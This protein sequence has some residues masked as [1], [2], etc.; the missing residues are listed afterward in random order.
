MIMK[1]IR[2][3]MGAGSRG[4]SL[5]RPAAQMPETRGDIGAGRGRQRPA[6]C[7][8]TI[9]LTVIPAKAG[10]QH[11]NSE[12]SSRGEL[13]FHWIPAFAGMTRA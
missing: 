4:W 10:I 2:V 5:L 1:G 11:K 7:I 12:F 6:R 3:F 13:P 9:C 8:K